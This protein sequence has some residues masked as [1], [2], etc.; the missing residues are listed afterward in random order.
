MAA[1]ATAAP[2][3]DT[4]RDQRDQPGLEAAERSMFVHKDVSSTKIY[5]LQPW[6]VSL[7]EK[8][9]QLVEHEN[10]LAGQVVRVLSD[11]PAPGR[12]GVLQSVSLQVTDGSH[13]V[14]V[15]VSPEA[16]QT[17][18]NAFMHLKLAGLTCR[19]VVLQKYRVCFQE[20]A[21]LEDCELYLK[22][23]R[24]IVL[25]I[26]RQ[27]IESSDGNQEPSVVKKIKELWL[28]NPAVKNAPSSDPSISQLIDAIGQNQLEILKENAEECLDLQMPKEKPV[29]VTDEVPVTEWEAERKTEVQDV[30]MV[31]VNTLVIPPEEE[32]VACDSSKTD[33][34]K[35]TSGKSSDD[36]TVSGDPSAVSQA[37]HAESLALSDSLEGS[38]DNPWNRVPSLS[39]TPSSSDEKTFQ[40]DASL[41]SQKDVSADSNTPDLLELCNQ[42]SPKRL[43]Q[44]EPVQTFSP[45][46]LC[47]YRNPSPVKTSTSQAA[48]ALGAACG[49]PCAAQGPQGSRGSQATLPTLSPDFPVLPSTSLQSM[50]D[51]MPHGEQACSSGTAFPPGALKPCPAPGRTRN[52][53]A[54]G[55]KRKLMVGDDEALLAPGGQQHPQGTPRGRGTGTGR[56]SELMSPRGAKKSRK[57][58]GLQHGKELEEEEKEEEEEEEQASSSAS[59]LSSRP[60]QRRT[61]EPYV[62]K[63][64]QYKYEAPSPELCQQIQSIRISKAM[65]KWACWILTEEEEEDS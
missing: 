39:L 30:F 50:P 24:F 49:A 43:P 46:L 34:N 56:R 18:E 61:L 36:R 53:A 7:L 8:D 5:V 23:Q 29:T 38:L 63:P 11:L 26:Q 13:Y 40:S 3:G 10:F 58:T 2:G 60:E 48:S 32:E 25:P 22:A 19:I 14:R 62:R 9:D 54:A 51:R 6:I 57:E 45:S 31:P 42:D 59:G 52:R 17:E 64:A 16:L 35:T 21:R 44:G 15:V 65:L 47:S 20:E 33:T 41:K 37:S 4:E 55:A 12:P 27:K 1:A 28:R